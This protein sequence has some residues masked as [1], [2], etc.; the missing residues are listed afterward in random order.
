LGIASFAK[1]LYVGLASDGHGNVYVAD[2][3]KNRILKI[4]VDGI[5]IVLAGS[6]QMGYRD[7]PSDAAQFDGPGAVA[8]DG[9]GNVLV[10]DTGNSLIRRIGTNGVVTTIAGDYRWHTDAAMQDRNGARDG[11]GTQARFNYPLGIAVDSTGTIYV[12]D[13]MNGRIRKISPSGTVSTLAGRSRSKR[14][15]YVD[16]SATEAVFFYPEGLALGPDGTLY[17]ADNNAIRRVSADGA[18]ST[19]AG[20]RRARLAASENA[21]FRYTGGYVDGAAQVAEFDAPVALAVDGDGYVYVADKNNRAIRRVA[22]NGSTTTVVDLAKYYPPP[23]HPPTARPGAPIG[24]VLLSAGVLATCVPDG[25]L[26]ATGI[27]R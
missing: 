24:I 14:T 19:L 23:T 21:P 10:A 5:A 12:A 20:G 15:G 6:G 11:I 13:S 22:P 26:R 25:V 16:G 3:F 18:V 27:E 2:S 9:N 4:G 7:G 8:V 17:V 1:G